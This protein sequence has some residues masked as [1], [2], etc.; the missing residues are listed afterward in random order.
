MRGKLRAV[1]DTVED[2]SSAYRFVLLQKLL[3]TI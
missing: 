2:G 3:Q 1:W